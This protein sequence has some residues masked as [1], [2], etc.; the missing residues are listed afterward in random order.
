MVELLGTSDE[1]AGTPLYHFLTD[2]SGSANLN[3]DYTTPQTATY[4]C[5]AGH[6][7]VIRRLMIW[8]ESRGPQRAEGYGKAGRLKNGITVIVARAG[9]NVDNLTGLPVKIGPHWQ[10]NCHDLGPE[11]WE[12]PTTSPPPMMYVSGRWSFNKGHTTQLAGGDRF[13]VHLRDD[14]TALNEHTMQIQGSLIPT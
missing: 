6:R 14:L 9:G 3:G 4:E 11:P 8:Y 1:H 10:R 13:E 12:E 2:E 7:A 5:P